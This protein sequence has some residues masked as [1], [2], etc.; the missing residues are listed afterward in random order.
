MRNRDIKGKEIGKGTYE[1][2]TKEEE[3]E[4]INQTKRDVTIPGGSPLLSFFIYC[5]KS[6][7]HFNEENPNLVT[8]SLTSSR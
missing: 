7:K 5:S 4:E 2:Q 3:D 8:K 1:K 6:S